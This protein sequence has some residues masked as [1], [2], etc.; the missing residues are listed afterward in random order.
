[1]TRAETHPAAEQVAVRDAAWHLAEAS[2]CMRAA[3]HADPRLAT[4][5]GTPH[6]QLQDLR[7]LLAERTRT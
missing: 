5:L 2:R 4:K 6:A 3:V 7:E 1:M